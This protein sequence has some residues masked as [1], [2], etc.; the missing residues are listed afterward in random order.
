VER[1]WDGLTSAISLGVLALT[2][3][4]TCR[5]SIAGV[6]SIASLPRERAIQALGS[7]L[8]ALALRLLLVALALGLADAVLRRVRHY[9]RQRMTRRE[10]LDEQR[11]QYGDP[12]TRAERARHMRTRGAGS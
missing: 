11:E 12:H 3:W 8:E 7:L 4:L 6:V 9:Q 5:S 1:G 2:L 10:A